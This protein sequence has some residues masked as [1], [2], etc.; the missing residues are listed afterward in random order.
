MAWIDNDEAMLNEGRP[1][2]TGRV[3]RAI[4]LLR[5]RDE[6]LAEADMQ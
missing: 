1:A 3:A 4:E 2:P 6:E 5:A